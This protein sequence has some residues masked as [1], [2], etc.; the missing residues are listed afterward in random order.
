[1]RG[2]FLC[3]VWRALWRES[4]C[5]AVLGSKGRGR[6]ADFSTA[7]PTMRLWA[8]SVEMTIHGWVKERLRLGQQLALEEADFSTAR[9]TMRLWAAS[10]EMT[11]H[12]LQLGNDWR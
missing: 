8:A 7:R 4:G 9:P 12:G 3:L 2:P 1:M 11:I 6:E 5:D 10:V